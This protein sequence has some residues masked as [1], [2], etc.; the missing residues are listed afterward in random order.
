MAQVLIRN[1]DDDTIESYRQKAKFKGISLEQELRN[2]LEFNKPF[3]SD[4]RLAVS[5]RLRERFAVEEFDVKAAVREG[6]DDEFDELE[7]RFDQQ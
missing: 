6:R 4:E 1:I 7:A 3:S 5:R 2:L